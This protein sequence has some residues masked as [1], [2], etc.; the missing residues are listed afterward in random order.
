METIVLERQLYLNK[1]N[2]RSERLTWMNKTFITTFLRE[3]MG[4]LRVARKGL[5]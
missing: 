2:Y 4:L 5:A 3:R 1:K